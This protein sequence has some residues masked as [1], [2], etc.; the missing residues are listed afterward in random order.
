ML[1]VPLTPA[2]PCSA[3]ASPRPKICGLDQ[4]KVLFPS[5][6]ELRKFLLGDE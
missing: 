4:R 6:D 5:D 1:N 3:A 2:L